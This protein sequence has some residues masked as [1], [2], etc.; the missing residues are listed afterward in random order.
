VLSPF[1]TVEEAYLAAKWLKERSRQVKL[2]LGFV[3]VVGR[4]DTYPKDRRGQPLSPVQFTIRAE[5]CP[6][7]RGVEEILR[8]FQNEL[9]SFQKA[10]DAVKKGEAKAVFVTGGY[11]VKG[12]FDAFAEKP[13]DLL[14][15]VS[16]LFHGP[17]TSHAKYVLPAAAFS[18][19]EGTFLNH[20]NLAQGIKRAARPPQETRSEGQLFADLALRRGLFNAAAVRK[21]LAAEVPYFAKLADGPG[22]L[23]VKLG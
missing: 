10:L 3:P 13:D 15:A 21:E 17:A 18:E 9:I 6:N 22:E 4:D 8:H 23:G 7:R 2:A 20:A 16:D 5:K 11:P 14:L 1:L 19:K 12:T